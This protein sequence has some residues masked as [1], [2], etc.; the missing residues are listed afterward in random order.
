[1]RAFEIG[2]NIWENG[3][4]LGGKENVW[5]KLENICKQWKNIWGKQYIWD[6][7]GICRKIGKT[8]RKLNILKIWRTFGERGE[9]LG[10][11]RTFVKRTFG[12]N[13]NFLLKM[14]HIWEKGRTLLWN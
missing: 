9:Q 6:Y 5:G 13:D 2:K 12:R 7:E 8:L 11:G 14:D 3:E 10:N 1:M 4:H